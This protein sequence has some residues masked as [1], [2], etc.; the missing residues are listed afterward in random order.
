MTN[1]YDVVLAVVDLDDAVFDN[2]VDTFDF[3][4]SLDACILPEKMNMCYVTNMYLFK[5]DKLV[6]THSVTTRKLAEFLMVFKNENIV[7]YQG[8]RD[9]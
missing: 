4:S 6:S 3:L 1:I 5:G 2:I 8:A 9:S 7:N